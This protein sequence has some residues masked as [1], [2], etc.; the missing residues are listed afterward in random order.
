MGLGALV[1][2]TLVVI[3]A[4]VVDIV[5]IKYFTKEEYVTI[6]GFIVV[7]LIAVFTIRGNQVIAK[8][9]VTVNFIAQHE[10]GNVEW[11]KRLVQLW[12][13]TSKTDK[14]LV[15]IVA[16]RS[17]E[18]SQ[19]TAVLNHMEMVAIAIRNHAI[20]EKIYKEWHAPVYVGMWDRSEA[21]IKAFRENRAASHDA[22]IEF[23]MLAARWRVE[24][25]KQEHAAA[26]NRLRGS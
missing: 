17:E 15:G 26:Q 5:F 4:L 19:V 18:V 21:F 12:K 10:I 24:A 9:Q 23:E 20:D 2:A 3:A 22:F 7:I 8:R 6:V 13:I 25:A 14:E 1:V 11:P 16:D